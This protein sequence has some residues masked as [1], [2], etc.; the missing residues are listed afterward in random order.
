[1]SYLLF[2]D[3][4]DNLSNWSVEGNVTTRIFDNRTVAHIVSG[5]LSE[6]SRIRKTFSSYNTVRFKAV[7]TLYLGEIAE[8][9]T[10]DMGFQIYSSGNWNILVIINY[11]YSILLFVRDVVNN[12]SDWV[13]TPQYGAIWVRFEITSLEN[14][15][16]FKLYDDVNGSLL[17]GWVSS[18]TLNTRLDEVVIGRLGYYANYGWLD[19]D[20]F[21]LYGENPP[22]TQPTPTPTPTPAEPVSELPPAIVDDLL[23]SLGYRKVGYLDVNTLKRDITEKCVESSSL[24]SCSCSVEG[25]IPILEPNILFSGSIALWLEMELVDYSI[26]LENTLNATCE[27]EVDIIAETETGN[28]VVAKTR[29][30]RCV[31]YV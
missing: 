19:V 29:Y 25:E 27:I 24:G 31:I 20:Y 9:G 18:I 22:P 26:P 4:F 17:Y 11:D 1:M 10:G 16:D 14:G 12:V 3:N 21:A 8:T 5:S 30:D 7:I 13:L 2:E 23:T 28:Y 6:T 15:V